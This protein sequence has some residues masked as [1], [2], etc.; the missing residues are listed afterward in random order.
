MKLKKLTTNR[1]FTLIELVLV[2]VVIGIIVAIA[3]QRMS[4]SVDT[5][6][7]EQTK[8]EMDQLA[9]AIAGNP[10][11]Y[12]SGTRTDFG[13]VGDIGAM[14]DSLGALV[15]NPGSYDTWDGPYIGTGY[16][17]EDFKKDAW[18]VEYLFTDTLIRSTGSG[19]NIDK[20]IAVN[21]AALLSNTVEG[22]VVDASHDVPGSD[23]T[24][25]LTIC[26][27]Y[28]NGLG[29]MT[30]DSTHPG[31]DGNFS[32]TGIPIGAHTLDVVFEAEDDTASYNVSVGPNSNTKLS[33]T[34]PADLW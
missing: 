9:L 1:A 26:L 21:S 8:K 27:N 10:A 31:P 17:E 14:P 3:T 23:D 24:L 16:N 4:Q 22:Y 34:F 29:G 7:H 18:G 32:F 12:A 33:I 15:A 11:V 19:S 2:I 25:S 30:T 20:I 13:Y 5:A 28:P 6:R